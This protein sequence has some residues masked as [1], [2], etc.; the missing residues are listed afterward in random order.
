MAR[1]GPRP[2]TTTLIL[3]G[4]IGGIVTANRLRRRL[5]REHRVILVN[6][7]ADFTLAASYLWV[8]TGQRTRT[9]ITRP[10]RRLERRGI[11][12]LIGEVD[13]IDPGNRTATV[14]GQT[15]DADNLVV[16]LGAD[17]AS[18]QVEGL[19]AT[20][21][22]YATLDGAERL[23]DQLLAIERGRVLIMTAA[24]LYK[25]PAAPYEA[26]LFAD[27]ILRRR[28]VRQD[29]EIA[30]HAAEPAPM[31]I[32]G[33]TISEA[34]RQILSQH[35]I[36][37]QPAH[38][39]TGVEPGRASFADGQE[40][41]FD[42]LAYMPPIRPPAVLAGSG[43]VGDSGWIEADRN[44][45]TTAFDGVHAIGDNVSIPLTMGK[46]LPR[47]G[48]FA[49]A[50]GHAVA[51]NIAARIRGD[52]PPARFDG[53]GGCFIEIG[54]GR[55]GYGSGDFYAE[56]TPS[57]TIRKPARRWHIGKLLLEQSILRRWL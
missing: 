45:L 3:G 31:G 23:H 20:G 9:Q 42:L 7:D 57:V 43:L 25:C 49:H 29:V 2:G 22:T 39:V 44:M 32:A 27:A 10:L 38:Q 6:R 11:E 55:A 56:P 1:P 37:Y 26:A 40:V 24:P 15:I 34:V 14:D 51:D 30:I 41:P 47:A 16:A 46:P 36:D 18:D 48:V 50:Q 35:E 4:G 33:P 21:Q 12:V 5:G 52:Q 54:S 53:T 17:Y 13:G 28:G 8:M 19:A